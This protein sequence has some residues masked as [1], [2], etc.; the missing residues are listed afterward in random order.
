MGISNVKDSNGNPLN[1]GDSV[2]LIKSL[3]VKGGNVT[4][5]QGTT[6]KKIRLTDNDEEVDCKIDGMSIVLK[7]C[8][9]KKK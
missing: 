7:T 2:S 1:D 3:K 8:F 9:L 5:K 4:L 6:I